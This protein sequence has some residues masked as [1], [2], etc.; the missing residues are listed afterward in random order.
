MEA[1]K[2]KFIGGLLASS[3]IGTLDFCLRHENSIKIEPGFVDMLSEEL[4]ASI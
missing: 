3:T 4:V 2:G 1:S